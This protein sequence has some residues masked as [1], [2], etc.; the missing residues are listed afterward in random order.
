MRQYVEY[1]FVNLE[2]LRIVNNATSKPGE[3]TTLSY[4]PGASVRGML[5]NA[6]SNEETFESMKKVLLS[7]RV[8]FL[9]AYPL[10]EMSGQ[11][12]NTIPSVKGF[13]ESKKNIDENATDHIEM[14]NVLMT[15]ELNPTYKRAKLGT[16][17]CIENDQVCYAGIRLNEVLNNN[18]AEHEVFRSDSIQKGYKFRGYIGF[19]ADPAVARN[20]MQ[21]MLAGRI[22]RIG[23]GRTA[24]YGKVKITDAIVMPEN[25][26][27]YAEYAVNNAADQDLY[28]CAVSDLAFRDENGELCGIENAI[29]QLQ[30]LLGVSSVT[31][32][33]CATSV[34]RR[35]GIN[36]M[37]HA[38]TPE[39]SMYEAGSVFRLHTAEAVTAERIRSLED[40]GI[41]IGTNEGYGRVL[42]L[43]NYEKIRYKK[44]TECLPE[45]S[46]QKLSVSEED[47]KSVLKI[48][49]RNMCRY[50]LNMK[51]RKLIIQKG[52]GLAAG[53]T[54]A[55]SH[56]RVTR[57]MIKS[58]Q[59]EPERAEEKLADYFAHAEEK[60]QSRR[61]NI[62]DLK[63]KSKEMKLAVE[64]LNGDYLEQI[65]QDPQAVY[66]G[67]AIE[68]LFS[69]KELKERK[70]LLI[71]AI[72]DYANRAVYGEERS[73]D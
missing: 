47:D 30:E 63:S 22:F 23:S 39:Y 73:D 43:K 56:L 25:S 59:Y 38:R 19:D 44:K 40:S 66:L 17:C 33:A 67:A 29:P 26:L 16:F 48:I 41:G 51:D 65:G 68:E 9:N 27:P 42:F 11:P 37:W 49:G 62:E 57:A 32:T 15:E 14:Q 12:C 61:K 5:M 69:E 10:L 52:S 31:L 2:P 1:E 3:T 21:T 20:V 8:S 34:V 4:V 18:I 54:A 72:L 46:V 64:L 35:N 53:K 36:R 60:E 28:M 55:D 13:Y 45:D 6:I 58:L 50:D 7:D 24:G 71:N 70:M